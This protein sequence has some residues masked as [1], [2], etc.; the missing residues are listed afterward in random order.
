MMSVW[1][2]GSAGAPALSPGGGRAGG[3]GGRAV[4]VQ[5]LEEPLALAEAPMQSPMRGLRRTPGVL[6]Q[7]QLLGGVRLVTHGQGG[8]NLLDDVLQLEQ[9]AEAGLVPGRGLHV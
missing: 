3:D 9:A 6:W 1:F 5:I 7:I 8:T 4:V 2:V